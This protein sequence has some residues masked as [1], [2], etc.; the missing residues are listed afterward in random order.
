MSGAGR[1]EETG[2]VLVL[3]KK[4]SRMCGGLS[5][6][7]AAGTLELLQALFDEESHEVCMKTREESGRETGSLTVVGAA[8]Q[9]VN[10][11]NYF[12]KL[13]SECDVAG[14]NPLPCMHARI[15][16]KR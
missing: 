6:L 15:Y 9:V 8:S 3:K 12:V 10:G 14:G 2:R 16:W 13:R 4:M 7:S 5:A 1:F 11:V